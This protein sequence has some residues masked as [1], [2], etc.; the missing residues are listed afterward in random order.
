MP[1]PLDNRDLIGWID[2]LLGA[3]RRFLNGLSAAV[4]ELVA[5]CVSLIIGGRP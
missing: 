4:E 3:P 5:F 2:G 1:D